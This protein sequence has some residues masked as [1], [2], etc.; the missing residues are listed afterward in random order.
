MVAFN[1]GARVEGKGGYNAGVAHM[2]EHSLFKGTAKRN[3]IEIQKQ[4]AFLGGFSNA[5]TSH[6]SVAYYISVPYE[7]IEP[8]LEILSDMVFNPIFP[9]DE[10]LKEKEVVKEE[11]ASSTD[12]PQSYIWRKFSS[13]FFSNYLSE[14]VIG[15]S[16]SI[17]RFTR[18]EIASF[19]SEFCQRK[20]AVVSVCSN[21]KKKDVKEMLNRHFGSANGKIKR[22]YKF[23]ESE[24]NKSDVLEIERPGIE[25]TYVWLGMPSIT[26]GSMLEPSAQV[27]MTILGRGMDSRLFT[28]VREKRGLVYGISS[29]FNDWQGGGLTLV[30]FSTRDQNV[31]DALEIVDNQ[32]DVIKTSLCSEEEVQRAKNKMKSSFYSAIEDS[33]SLCYWAVKQKLYKV[34]S[35]SEYMDNVEKVSREDILHTAKTMFDKDR[36]LT[37]LCRGQDTE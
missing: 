32:I 27:L 18:D 13:Q 23:S 14:P 20:D 7:N 37:L 12:D 11:E 10:F 30:E 8:C 36:R 16:D 17:D 31:S 29:S 1:A 24:Y 15:T 4:I 19:H 6:E 33:Y 34:P 3:S 28:E 26:T 25:H 35:I 2:L 5:F 22:K 9:E 21:L